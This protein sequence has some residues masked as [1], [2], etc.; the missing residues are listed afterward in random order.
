[1]SP[2][3]GSCGALN[4][5]NSYPAPIVGIGSARILSCAKCGNIYSIVPNADV[6]SALS[7]MQDQINQ[8]SYE[9]NRMSRALIR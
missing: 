7:Q 6:S 8:L 1:M 2:K 3:C 4:S 5:I 9:V